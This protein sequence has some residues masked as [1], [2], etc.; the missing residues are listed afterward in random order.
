MLLLASNT[1]ADVDFIWTTIVTILFALS[2]ISERISNLIKLQFKRYYIEPQN[3]VEK[4]IKEKEIM[5]LALFS[6]LFVSFVS[7]AD[8]FTLINEAKLIPISTLGEPTAPWPRTLMGI[9]LS[10]VFISMGS[11]F[12]HDILDIVLEFSKLRKYTSKEIEED[13]K[14][15]NHENQEKERILLLDQAQNIQ[16]RLPNMQGYVG[17]QVVVGE[18]AKNKVKMLFD[19]G[20]PNVD[21]KKFLQNYFGEDKVEFESTDN[22]GTLL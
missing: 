1:G 7:G 4:K 12:W 19:S 13:V 5:W 9:F 8:F 15:K 17:Y 3:D 14:L 6:G 18:G 16:S 20:Q 2:L 11:R 10:G 22:K 21:D